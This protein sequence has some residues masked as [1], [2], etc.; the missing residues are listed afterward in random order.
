MG[1]DLAAFLAVYGAVMD[2]DLTSWSIGGSAPGLL[3]G[4]GLKIPGGDGISNSHNKYESD[5]SPTR[6]DL[7]QYGNTY[8]VILP[9]FEDLFSRQKDA[10]TAN[11]NLDVLTD[12]RKDRFAQSIANNK[13]FFNGPFTGVVVQPAAYTFIYRFMGNKSAEHPEGVLNQDV[14]KSFF[15]ITGTPGSFKWTEGYERIPDNWCKYYL[16]SLVS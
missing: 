9:Q 7:Y 15:S 16:K 11:Y 14:L 5:V 3:N 2:G 13:Q 8:K 12:F 1:L 10:A 6:P 4:I